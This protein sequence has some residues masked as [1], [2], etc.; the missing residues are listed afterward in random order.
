MLWAV[1]GMLR[2]SRAITLTFGFEERLFGA[3]EASDPEQQCT[4]LDDAEMFPFLYEPFIDI[5]KV[6]E[7][8]CYAQDELGLLPSVSFLRR[9][10]GTMEKPPVMR[11]GNFRADGVI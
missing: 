2:G 3:A 6:N 4:L 7:Y 8:L 11:Q 9:N 10:V 5:P 1:S